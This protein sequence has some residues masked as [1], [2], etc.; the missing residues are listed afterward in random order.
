MHLD[1]EHVQR[2]LHGELPRHAEAVAR[3]HVEACADCRAAIG[4]AEH[5][6]AEVEALLQHLDHPP[7]RVDARMIARRARQERHTWGRWA[8][9]IALAL[10]VAGVSYAFPGSPFPEWIRGVADRFASASPR[11]PSSPPPGE[12]NDSSVGGIAVDPGRQLLIFFTV[13]QPDAQARISLTDRADVVVRAPTAS[14]TYTS[15]IDRLVI[16]NAH[17]RG[18]FEIEIPRSASRVE[19]RVAGGRIFLKDGPRV[20]AATP[21]D[22][23]G[24]YVLPLAS[25]GLR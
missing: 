2:L 7:P 21:P 11:S 1:E 4:V 17:S 22:S 25:A 9:G 18:T 15:D 16:A 3:E 6:E 8:A 19:I 5:E 23:S 14:A 20:T 13:A 24:Q 10:G 12:P